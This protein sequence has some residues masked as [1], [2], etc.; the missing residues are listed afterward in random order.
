[1]TLRLTDEDDALLAELAQA[2][3]GISKQQAALRAIREQAAQHAQRQTVLALT[4]GV[5]E[6]YAEALRR[7]GEGP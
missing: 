4:A 6:R 2:W 7:L 1:M 3:G 5:Q